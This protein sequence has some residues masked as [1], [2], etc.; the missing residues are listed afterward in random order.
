MA[1]EAVVVVDE[2][3]PKAVPRGNPVKAVVTSAIVQFQPVG[4]VGLW[5]CG[6]V[7]LWGCGAV[8]HCNHKSTRR[9]RTQRHGPVGSAANPANA[10]PASKRCIEILLFT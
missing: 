9:I 8:A 10:I 6:A 5:G 3:F 4:A 1:N 7:G 2:V